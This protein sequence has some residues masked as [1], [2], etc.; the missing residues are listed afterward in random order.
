VK[1]GDGRAVL[2]G[3]GDGVTSMG[4]GIGDGTGTGK[5]MS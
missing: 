2:T 4:R 3:F 5:S 1:K